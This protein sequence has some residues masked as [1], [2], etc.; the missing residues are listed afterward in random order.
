MK[1]IIRLFVLAVM[2]FGSVQVT[3]A[4]DPKPF[5]PIDDPMCRPID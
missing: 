2:L 3:F 1:K 5:C 4:G